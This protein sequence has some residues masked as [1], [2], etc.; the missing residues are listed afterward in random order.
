M[1]E[2]SRF[3]INTPAIAHETIDGEVVMVNLNNGSYYSTDK[4]GAVIWNLIDQ[5]MTVKQIIELIEREY[6]GKSL[7]I[8][9]DVSE[10]LAELQEEELIIA[11]DAAGDDKLPNNV[12]SDDHW[13]VGNRAFEKPALQKFTDMQ[14]LLLL[15]PIHDVDEMGW[16]DPKKAS[17]SNSQ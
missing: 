13:L 2:S 1:S 6:S 10:L 14:D 3:K 15:D 12:L 11:I 5:G 7:D 8:E 9:R 4:V 17:R 16:P